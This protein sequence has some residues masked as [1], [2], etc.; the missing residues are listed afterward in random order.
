MAEAL[1]GNLLEY[2]SFQQLF[3]R[4]LRPGARSVDEKHELVRQAVSMVTNFNKYA[5]SVPKAM[6]VSYFSI[7]LVSLLQF[8]SLI[9]LS[10]LI[11]LGISHR[12]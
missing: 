11:V 2:A 7:S 4:R 9:L 6:C 3:T 10:F 12:W 5:S 1:V 8:A